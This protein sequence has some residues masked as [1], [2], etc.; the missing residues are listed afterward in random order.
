MAGNVKRCPVG[1]DCLHS[2]RTKHGSAALHSLPPDLYSTL[3]SYL[4]G[5]ESLQ[6]ASTC[7]ALLWI[8][9]CITS[10]FF[11]GP[12]V[13]ALTRRTPNLRTLRWQT[14]RPRI[15]SL[16][17]LPRLYSAHVL[18]RDDGEGGGLE[19]AL[20][21]APRPCPRLEVL[22]VEVPEGLSDQAVEWCME[23]AILPRLGLL[24][25]GGCVSLGWIRAFLARSG[26]GVLHLEV[27]GYHFFSPLVVHSFSMS[28]QVTWCDIHRSHR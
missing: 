5:Y 3:A 19:D 4:K 13:A 21:A 25:L 17:A 24:R 14:R 10:L 27:G 23:G 26:G 7:R 2:K 18:W 15:P 1:S 20:P 12:D 11:R 16:A 6:L 9:E 22:A 28:H 8:G